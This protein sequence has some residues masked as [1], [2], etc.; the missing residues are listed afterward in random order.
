M[1]GTNFFTVLYIIIY[2]FKSF[3]P[4]ISPSFLYV[5]GAFW[6]VTPPDGMC[7]QFCTRI[8]Y[9][10]SSKMCWHASQCKRRVAW[11]S[12]CTALGEW[13]VGTSQGVHY[14]A[15]LSLRNHAWDDRS[16]GKSSMSKCIRSAQ[17]FGKNL[18]VQTEHTKCS[19]LIIVIHPFSLSLHLHMQ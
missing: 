6:W 14:L 4:L 7:V 10:R 17:G 9:G 16:Y 18:S 3:S 19:H 8:L 1:T 11:H 15:D 2:A 12:N 5:L 13:W